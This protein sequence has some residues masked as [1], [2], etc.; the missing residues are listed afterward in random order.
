VPL[1]ADGFFIERAPYA[2]VAAS[3]SRAATSS[4][5]ADWPGVVKTAAGAVLGGSGTFSVADSFMDRGE[6]TPLGDAQPFEYTPG[7]LSDAA[8]RLAASTNNPNYAAKMLG[9]DRKTFGAIL[10]RFKP[11]NG[12]GPADNVIWHDNGDVYFK[13][14]YIGNFHDWA[15]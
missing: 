2:S 8:D 12:L 3:V 14:D 11:G 7:I 1:D 6:L 9:Y 13:G 5:G 15:N 4:G 10:H